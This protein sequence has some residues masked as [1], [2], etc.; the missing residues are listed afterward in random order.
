M[1]KALVDGVMDSVEDVINM[2]N[3]V[4]YAKTDELKKKLMEE[5]VT[6]EF[7]AVYWMNKFEKRL[8]ENEKRGNKNGYIVG[9]SLTI[10]DLKLLSL[11][12][13][14]EYKIDDGK[15]IVNKYPK[16]KKL[17]EI[18]GANEKIKAFNEQF[19]KNVAEYKEKGTASFRFDGKFVP[20]SL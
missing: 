15:E 5:F 9:D 16:I 3:K 6:N 7:Q 10:A 14:F 20:G 17:G 1:E 4:I 19:D 8:E 18:L 13:M 12:L 11:I 2:A